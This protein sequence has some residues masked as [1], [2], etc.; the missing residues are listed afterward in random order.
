M[1]RIIIL[2]L[3]VLYT[4]SISAQVPQKMSYQAVIRNS[5]NALL[6]SVEVGLRISILQ[7]SASGTVV[8]TE[9]HTPTTNSNGL[10]SIEIGTGIDFDAINWANGPY[11]LKTETDPTGG[12]NYT[13]TGISELLS[14]P[15][16]FNAITAQNFTG[17]I[18]EI[19]PEYSGSQAANITTTDISNLNNLSGV[20]TGDQD[21]S[22]LATKTDLGDSI[23]KVR[24]EIPDVTGFLDSET[25]P[26]Y[27]GSQAANI[28]AIDITNLGNLSGTNTGDQDLLTLATKVAL[29][30]STAKLRTEIPGPADGSETKVTN[31]TNIIITGN[32]TTITPYIAN[33]KKPD[34]YLG[35]DTLGGIVYYIYL[36]SD[37]HQQGLIVSKTESIGQWQTANSTTNAN[38]SWDGAYNTP[39][40]N[41]SPA[42]DYIM[43]LGAGWYLP[44]IDELS[45]LWQA[46]FH[47]NKAMNSGGF[48]LLS[49]T[50]NYWSSTEIVE[51]GA[52][53][54]QFT[55]ASAAYSFKTTS[56][57][58]RAVR[59]F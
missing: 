12:I 58:L 45:L 53:F 27:T 47:V 18:N 34:F 44:S 43:G 13:I 48:T 14:V 28:T 7:G 54:F 5:S 2:S 3:T 11:F 57:N 17:E 4:V 38:R 52:W 9:I 39:L 25:D 46:R 31:G 35:K 1:K 20:N 26:E 23:A 37:G 36:N 42:A 8:Y 22:I 59:A 32:G 24:Y 50:A 56:L 15:F 55:Y 6:S 49:N 30:D 51:N 16:A 10:I 19:D 33:V 41:N 29:G 21:L 40:M